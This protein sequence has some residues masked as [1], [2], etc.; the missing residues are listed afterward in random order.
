MKG[1]KTVSHSSRRAARKEQLDRWWALSEEE[2]EYVKT[3]F[4]IVLTCAPPD[5]HNGWRVGE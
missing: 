2:R 5:E 4:P 1:A 3:R